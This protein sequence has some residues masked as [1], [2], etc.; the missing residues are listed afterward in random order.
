M[1]KTNAPPV[2]IPEDG[3]DM[4]PRKHEN[5]DLQSP[6]QRENT[7]NEGDAP[8]TGPGPAHNLQ[9]EQAHGHAPDSVE[10]PTGHQAQGPTDPGVE[11]QARRATDPNAATADVPVEPEPAP[12]RAHAVPP[13]SPALFD[14]DLDQAHT[15]WRDLQATFVDDPREA[16][17]RAD[18]LV[19]EI[20][21]TLTSSLT[22]RTSELRDR[23]KHADQSDTEQLRLALRDYRAMLEQLLAMPGPG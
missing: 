10:E 17:E 8:V 5:E 20:V 21:I 9:Q 11:T 12:A 2:A 13:Q 16:M 6:R 18:G 3:D 22:T 7:V 14:Q 15:R 1:A 4:D 23:W 19:E